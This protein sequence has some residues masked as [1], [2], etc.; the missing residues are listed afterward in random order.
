MK[1]ALYLRRSSNRQPQSI[2]DQRRVCLRFAEANDLEVVAEYKDGKSGTDSRNRKSFLQMIN[3][4]EAPGCAFSHILVYDVSRFGRV[5]NDEAGYWRHRL[6]LSGVDVK[7]VKENFNG[8]DTDDLVRP[9][10][11]WQARDKAIGL[12]LDTIRG[13]ISRAEKGRWNGGMPPDGFDLEYC[14]PAGKPYMRM[15][16][17][18]NGDGHW[19]KEIYNNDGKLDRTLPEGERIS[20][21]KS[22]YCHLVPGHHERIAIVQRGFTMCGIDDMGYRRIADELNSEGVLGPKG[23]KWTTGSVRNM[24]TNPLYK[25]AMVWN[26]KSFA[27]IHR[28]GRREARRLSKSE[29]RRQRRNGGED[30]II[31]EGTH[32][33]IVDPQLFDLVQ[34]K[35]KERGEKHTAA[36]FRSG[37]AKDSPYLLTGLVRCARCGRHFQGYTCSRKGPDATTVRVK[38][39]YYVCNGYVN[40]GNSVCPRV[41]FRKDEIERRV[42]DLVG[43]RVDAL[44]ANGGM[45]KLRSLI[46]RGLKEDTPDPDR[47]I[48]EIRRGLAKV[49]QTKKRLVASLTAKNK[50]FLDEEFVELARRKKELDARLSEIESMKHKEVDIDAM[51]DGIMASV[52]G[53]KDLFPYGALEEQKEFIRLFVDG[54]ELDPDRRAGKAYVKRFP[55]PK[56]GAEKPL[57][58]CTSGA[59]YK[60]ATW[61]GRVLGR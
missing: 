3:D 50:E 11:Q 61:V 41:A 54:I 1:A 23:G 47:E 20:V 24:L 43:P 60:P 22:D 28:I 5:D 53:F 2:E 48:K 7:Y 15:R 4:A 37:R 45:A 6:H 16:F 13:Q 38:T 42:L 57:L 59:R 25:G 21:P 17:V 39:M 52:R 32:E 9:V 8:D 40:S 56:G 27:K 46:V 34:R 44:L 49:E 19:R 31:K 33:A 36:V 12:S 10:R 18:A 29:P 26:R 14:D 35:I 55:V 58:V 51:V 30:W